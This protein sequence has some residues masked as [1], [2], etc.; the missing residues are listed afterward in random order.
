MDDFK[1]EVNDKGNLVRRESYD[2]EFKQSFHYGDSLHEYV[3]SLVGMANN[4]GGQIIFGVQDQ[5]R[6][7]VGLS[8]DKF[9]KLD[10]TKINAIILEYFSSDISYSI[11]NIYWNGKVFGVLKVTEATTKPI[12]CRKTQGKI[13]RE[14]AVYYR[15][16]GETKEIKYAELSALLD[17]ERDKEKRLWMDHIQKIGSVGPANIHILDTANGVM[18]VGSST[19]LIDGS[20]I[21]QIKFIREGHFVEKG[22][23][24]ALKL[25]GEVAGVL[26]VD[27]IIYAES[28]YPYTAA[29]IHAECGI[30][31]YE[32]Q[33]LDW[34]YKI[35]GNARFH[36]I[37][38]TGR[39]SEIHKYS[40]AVVDMI[41]AEIRK[42]PDV[43]AK[44]KQA[45]SRSKKK[46]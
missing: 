17:N 8:N 10:A 42:D 14:G 9:E 40:K 21:D 7:P 32:L 20:V 43:V 35:K 15:Y 3:R 46:G 4:R 44:T 38:K 33:A 13:L 36:T 30:N 29:H 22:G 24:P 12:I 39:K 19:V 11:R 26:D 1:I 37:V 6:I 41:R 45:Y 16:R 31:N 25:A 2:L 23:A 34:K 28:A 27:R 5:P 18:D